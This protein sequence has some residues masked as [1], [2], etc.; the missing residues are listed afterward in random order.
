[1]GNGTRMLRLVAVGPAVVMSTAAWLMLTALLPAGA[2]GLVLV[3]VPVVLAVLWFGRSGR[4]GRLVNQVGV[5]LAGAREPTAKE[6]EVLRPVIARLVELEVDPTQLLVSRPAR[7]F[8]TVRP[9]GRDQVVVSPV[10]IEVV[11]RRQFAVEH[12]AALITHDIGWLRAQ[13]T[14]AAVAIAAW[15]LPWRA[16]STMASGLGTAARRVPLVEFAWKLRL[17]VGTVAVIQSAA[18]GRMTSAVLVAALLAVTYTTPAARRAHDGRLQTAA[19]RYVIDRGLGPTLLGA[20]AQ[21]GAPRPEVE[22]IRRLQA[23]VHAEASSGSP[24]EPVVRL[25]P[26]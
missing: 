10:L 20:L 3:V 21:V 8:P 9:F 26:S 4:V 16:L 25:V 22:R 17:L 7:P 12:A 6:L 13:P 15:A 11:R 14:R 1:V 2:G 24:T 18:E 5:L 19:D 23:V